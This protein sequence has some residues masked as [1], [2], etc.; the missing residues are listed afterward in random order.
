MER[1]VSVTVDGKEIPLNDFVVEMTE[2]LV[3]ALVTPLKGA[4][5]DKEIT[6][7]VGPAEKK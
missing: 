6:I 7:K 1:E 4:D 3:R 5:P 2:G